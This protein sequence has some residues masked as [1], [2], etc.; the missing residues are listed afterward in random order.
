MVLGDILEMGEE[1]ERIHTDM[2]TFV[3][4]NDIDILLTLGPLAER[5]SHGAIESGMAKD[6]SISFTDK[7]ELKKRLR[8]EVKEG[9]WILIKGSRG[10]KMEEVT[11]DIL[12]H[13]KHRGWRDDIKL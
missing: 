9:D 4:G 12:E 13:L 6:A 5:I 1:A 7:S 8:A 11:V 3:Y 10:M 2:G